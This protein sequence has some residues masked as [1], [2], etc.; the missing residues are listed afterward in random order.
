MIQPFIH[1]ITIGAALKNNHQHNS[2]LLLIHS[3]LCWL[4]SYAVVVCGQTEPVPDQTDAIPTST[5]ASRNMA[6]KNH[7]QA[8][9]EVFPEN[10]IVWLQA[11]GKPLLALYLNEQRGSAR[12]GVII[13]AE[14]YHLPSERYW[15]NNLRQTLP[16]KQW[17]SLVLTMPQQ[18]TLQQPTQQDQTTGEA[19]NGNTASE[20]TA[21]K[22]SNQRQALAVIDAAVNYYNT[23]GVFNIAIISE[24]ASTIYALQ[25]ISNINDTEKRTQI[26]GLALVNAR[27]QFNDTKLIDLIGAQQLPMLDIYLGLDYRDQREAQQRKTAGRQLAPGQYVQ[28]ALPRVATIWSAREDRLSKRIRG[29]LDRT[30]SGFEISQ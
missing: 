19:N 10:E 1:A 26:R 7:Q 13:L 11:E 15:I 25:Y 18:Q 23:L 5:N 3:L 16:T 8:L 12:G 4:L 27:N 2:K 6:Q 28:T 24:G 30:A 14:H 17:H 21:H 20:L 9:S 29:W 22:E